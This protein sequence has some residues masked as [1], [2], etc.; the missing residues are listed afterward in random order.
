TRALI[1]T[2][3]ARVLLG[4]LFVHGIGGA[5]YDQ[6]TDRIIQ[7][8]FGLE[9]PGYVVVSGT[10]HVPF[11]RKPAPIN[12]AKL[13][14]CSRKLQFHPESFVDQS[15]LSA[16]FDG[17]T[18]ADWIAEKRRWIETE[19]TNEN[20]KLRCRSIRHANEALQPAVAELREKWLS[21]IST[22]AQHQRAAKLFAS[23]E[24]S[25]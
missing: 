13:F 22:Y 21:A 23:R 14:Q 10:L 9:P 6:L 15:K 5:K 25:F 11:A 19:Q 8:F 3:A 24:Y 12:E 16:V 18:A 7:C 20:A 2:L 17:R 1:T 4:D